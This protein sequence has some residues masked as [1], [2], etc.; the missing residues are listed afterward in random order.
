MKNILRYFYNFS[1]TVQVILLLTLLILPMNII[2]ILFTAQVRDA[3]VKQSRSSVEHTASLYIAELDKSIQTTESFLFKEVGEN[4]YVSRLINHIPGD[5]Y[6]VAANLYWQQLNERTKWYDEADGYFFYL[7]SEEHLDLAL[8]SSYSTR[9]SLRE[10][11]RTLDLREVKGSW[12]I[13]ENSGE[14][15]LVS[16]YSTRGFYYGALI[17][18]NKFE[19]QIAAGLFIEDASVIL[20]DTVEEP[21]GN[22]EEIVVINAAGADVSARISF[23]RNE[24]LRQIPLLQ[25]IGPMLGLVYFTCIPIL[26]L[27]IRRI[28]I[29]PLKRLN[30]AMGELEAGNP[31]YRISTRGENREAQE[32]TLKFNS[33]ADHLKD[34]KIK[35]YEKELERMD[36]EATNLRLQVNPHFILNCLNIIFSLARSGNLDNI[37]SFTK[38]LADY[39]RF[40]LWNTSGTVRL[41]QELG[42]VENYLT[43]Q[44]IRFPGQFSYV[45]NFDPEV[46]TIMIPPFLI[47]NF[48]ENCT[49]YAIL[50]DRSIEILVIARREENELVLSICDTGNGMDEKTRNTLERGEILEDEEGKH[51]GVWNCLRRLKMIYGERVYFRI[52]SE[53]GNGTQIFMKIPLEGEAD[54]LIDC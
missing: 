43:I 50:P 41:E 1:V 33:M 44:K 36:I 12:I 11:I 14:K 23:N 20:T 2:L 38:Y 30:M 53:K 13:L 4:L 8:S 48:V 18:L 27:I 37:K 54:D 24:L 22:A 52:T 39:L 29:G 32:L 3:Y 26:I 49:K 16:V 7:E 40:S 31:D 25:Q 5:Y 51:I 28:L 45:S 9:K 46:M 19:N 35:V 21:Q 47:Q 17:N 6:V 42:C 15:W 10:Y 34:L